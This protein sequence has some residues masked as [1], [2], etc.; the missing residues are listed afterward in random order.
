MEGG[1]EGEG[2]KASGHDGDGYMR[3]GEA[4]RGCNEMMK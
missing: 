3:W 4:Y 2:S 1:E